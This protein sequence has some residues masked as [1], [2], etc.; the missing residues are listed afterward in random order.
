M[1]AAPVNTN[2]FLS[3]LSGTM[4]AAA[5]P[6]PVADHPTDDATSV[7]PS[8]GASSE[9]RATATASASDGA[10]AAAS[11][12]GGTVAGIATLKASTSARRSSA[13]SIEP[14]AIRRPARGRARD[15]SDN[16][17]HAMPI[18]RAVSMCDRQSQVWLQSQQEE[19]APKLSPMLSRRSCFLS[20]A[21]SQGHYRI[22]KGEHRM[23]EW[24]KLNGRA[25]IASESN[26]PEHG[27]SPST[28]RDTSP[29]RPARSSALRSN[30]IATMMGVRSSANALRKAELVWTEP[31]GPTNILCVFKPHDPEVYTCAVTV[32]R[33]MLRSRPFVKIHVEAD[34]LTKI[35]AAMTA[36]DVAEFEDGTPRIASWSP[37]PNPWEAGDASNI[38]PGVD[39]VITLGGDGTLLHVANYFQLMAPPILSFALGSLGFLT[40]FDFERHEEHLN[41][42]FDGR[43][44]ITL[45]TRLECEIVRADGSTVKV[46]PASHPVWNVLNE[47][48]ID[49]GP[50][51][52]I[53]QLDVYCDGHPIT[54]VQG[55]GL[56]IATPTGSTAYSVSAGGSMVHPTVP[57]ML[58]TPIC[59]HSLSFRPIIMPATVELKVVCK[60][61][62]RTGAWVSMDGK[63]RQELGVGDGIRVTTSVWPI[64]TVSKQD[65]SKDWFDSLA[66]NLNWNIREMQKANSS[67]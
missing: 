62:G 19:D 26:T 46:D 36:A 21:H 3:P 32:I 17:D 27:Q 18:S 52:Y 6:G 54:C 39:L 37:V 61:Q 40:P 44:I 60:P 56:I 63:N 28:S 16:P 51:P 35:V 25:A 58:M 53:A 34:A 20:P 13:P 23:L 49:R 33:F 22:G 14:A 59:P 8:P 55:D 64:P 43:A 1:P 67:Q 12:V 65:I 47:V 15:T 5:P 29:T 50:A 11:A 4:A 48:V 9:A 7:R 24:L 2:P 30:M 66:K 10:A 57:C 41:N 38:V 42:C 45:R 31:S